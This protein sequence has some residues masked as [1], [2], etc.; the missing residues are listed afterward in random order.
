MNDETEF[1]EITD[2]LNIGSES[3]IKSKATL[4]ND[5]LTGISN[6]EWGILRENINLDTMHLEE[7]PNSQS[8]KSTNM[9]MNHQTVSVII[10][11]V[12]KLAILIILIIPIVRSC[13]H[14]KSTSTAQLPVIIY[15]TPN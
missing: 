11:S 12:S 7:D 13:I 10:L 8:V 14:R 5:I 1:L 9:N 3:S 2:E 15:F 6:H 4:N